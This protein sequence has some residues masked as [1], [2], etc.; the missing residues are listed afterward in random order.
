MNKKCN[1]NWN[2]DK[3]PQVRC[4]M[5]LP[6]VSNDEVEKIVISLITKTQVTVLR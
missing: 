6:N 1:G 3:I 5:Y 4:S 2:P